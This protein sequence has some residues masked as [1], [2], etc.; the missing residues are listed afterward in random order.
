MKRY[1]KILER[2]TIITIA[3]LLAVF[4][5]A[6][7]V[8][9]NELETTQ[10]QQ[11]ATVSNN[12]TDTEE[13]TSPTPAIPQKLKFGSY[14]IKHGGDAELDMTKLANNITNA[15]LDVV[16]LQEVDQRTNRVN[17]ID[18]M[19]RLSNHT[20]YEYYAFFKAIDF[21]GGE[22]GVGILSKYPIVETERMELYSGNEE[23]RVLGRAK[24]DVNGLTVNFFVTHLSYE[25]LEIRTKQFKQVSEKINEYENFIVT[26][27]FNTSDFEEYSVIE[28]SAM[29][30]NADY[31]IPTFPSGNSSIDNIVYE[32][33]AWSF[34]YPKTIL[35]SYS[36]HYMLYAEAEYLK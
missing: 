31:S 17:N 12:T 25:S 7:D 18:T 4:T 22:Y 21:Q 9:K 1:L 5:T 32:D 26:G 15:K 36:D 23:Q 33:G 34:S 19:Q 28:N 35:A 10:P 16:G 6:C 8:E 2:L 27:D 11:E 13:T 30:N 24:I 3:L 14:N 20:G 29:V